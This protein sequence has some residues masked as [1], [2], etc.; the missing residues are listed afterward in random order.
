MYIYFYAANK[1][2]IKSVDL[3]SR[4]KILRFLSKNIFVKQCLPM[5]IGQHLIQTTQVVF[6]DKFCIQ[7]Q[8]NKW[9]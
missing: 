3:F 5:L 9:P 2:L 8:V 6:K 7:W 1:R 4:A